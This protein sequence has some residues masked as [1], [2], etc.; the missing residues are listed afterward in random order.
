MTRLEPMRAETFEQN[1]A[2]IANAVKLLSADPK[3]RRQFRVAGIYETRSGELLAEVLATSFGPVIVYA[4]GAMAHSRNT[5]MIGSRQDRDR[6]IR[7]LTA[8][9]GQTFELMS[10]A[11]SSHEITAAE[12]VRFVNDEAADRARVGNLTLRRGH[13]GSPSH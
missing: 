9:A 1:E 2:A 13:A 11:N 4:T 10:R 12:L 8:A 6:R 3:R 5:A 7:P